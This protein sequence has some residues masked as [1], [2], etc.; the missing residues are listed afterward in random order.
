MSLCAYPLR[1]WDAP[2]P[3]VM[4]ICFTP[5][6]VVSGF[7]VARKHGGEQGVA[8]GTAATATG[9]VVVFLTAA[10]YEVV[11]EPGV[12]GLSWVLLGLTFVPAALFFGALW[13]YLGV[14]LARLL[15]FVGGHGR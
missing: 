5:A 3:L 2:V 8:A 13:G 9:H 7:L 11:N 15:R 12:A 1:N 10:V 4:V 14:A 6:F